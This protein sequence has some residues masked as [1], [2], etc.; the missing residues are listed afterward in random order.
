MDLIPLTAFVLIGIY[1]SAIDIRTHRIPN[2]INAVAA[3]VIPTLIYLVSGI[4]A[5]IEALKIGLLY[6]VLF[7]LLGF[8]SKNSLGMGD[9]K[10]SF[11]CGL[12]IG[13][14]TPQ[15]WLATLWFMFAATGIFGIIKIV[16]SRNVQSNK[17]SRYM[18]QV[19]TAIA[20]GPFMAGSTS[21][22]VLNSLGLPGA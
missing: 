21:L 11:G 14:Y 15:N 4:S 8:I 13:Y 7:L 19:G 20:F 10:F 6:F 18:T 9:V 22:V 12:I 5:V 3:L 2:Q 17:P 16:Q 1:V